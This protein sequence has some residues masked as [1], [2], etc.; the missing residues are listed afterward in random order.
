MSAYVIDTEQYREFESILSALA[1][2]YAVGLDLSCINQY[3]KAHINPTESVTSMFTA[4][5]VSHLIK[6]NQLSVAYRYN[7]EPESLLHPAF[8][9]QNG[10]FLMRAKATDY[11]EL[12]SFLEC[13]KYQSCELTPSDMTTQ[14]RDLMESVDELIKALS[15][16]ALKLATGY[17][18]SWGRL[19]FSFNKKPEEVS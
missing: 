2:N 13:W 1:S 15:K 18:P 17:E 19:A 4:E 6:L 3:G 10:G 12:I 5:F 7:E 14:Q 9:P 16:Y 8:K 11:M